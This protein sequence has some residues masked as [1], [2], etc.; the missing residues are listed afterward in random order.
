M[1]IR[2]ALLMLRQL[3]ADIEL[4]ITDAS[5]ALVAATIEK[6]PS[7]IPGRPRLVVKPENVR[8]VAPAAEPAIADSIAKPFQNA[9]A[10]IVQDV[11]DASLRESGKSVD[12]AIEEVLGDIEAPEAPRKRGGK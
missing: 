5:G 11:K 9:L 1:R 8:Q 7:G 4:E 10:D 6:V 3:S 2:D 12:A